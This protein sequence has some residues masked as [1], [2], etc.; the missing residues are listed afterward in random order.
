MGG[1]AEEPLKLRAA[2]VMAFFPA[3]AG[4]PMP[5]EPSTMVFD[6]W[7]P[8]ITSSPIATP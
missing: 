2:V 8:R 1:V 7:A 4:G 6:G 3:A 5:K